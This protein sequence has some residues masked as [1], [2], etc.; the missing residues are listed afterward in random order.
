MMF[1]F[2][3]FW[4]C[5]VPLFVAVDAI[6]VLPLY[7]SLTDGASPAEKRKTIISSVLTA[8]A[9]GLLF[10]FVG[11]AI[12][13]VMGITVADFMVA[14]GIILFLIAIGDLITVDKVLRKVNPE[15]L[16]PVP[17]GV[18]L[19]VGPAVLTTIMLLVR[20]YGF[21]ITAVATISNILIAG[22]FFQLS[23]FIMKWIGKSGSKIISRVASLFLAAIAVMLVRKGLATM[24]EQH[25]LF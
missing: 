13:R 21:F 1:D 25:L 2:H 20:E 10:L 7:L 3:S 16:G 24:F 6:G 23:E 8:S 19:I 12:L 15:A 18:P 14:G 17:I 4:L 5:F 22:V 11:E 9:V